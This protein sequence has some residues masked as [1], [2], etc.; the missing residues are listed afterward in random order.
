MQAAR[1]ITMK[2]QSMQQTSLLSYF[3][4]LPH[5]TTLISQQPSISVARLSTSKKD[6]DFLKVQMMVNN[7]SNTGFF[8]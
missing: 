8:N 2:S 6:Y 1:E 3:K 5:P 7:L 4:K